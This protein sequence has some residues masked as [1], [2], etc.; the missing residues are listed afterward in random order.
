MYALRAYT[1]P[2]VK[3]A[4]YGAVTQG[5]LSVQ[6]ATQR[7]CETI[8]GQNFACRQPLRSKSSG[9]EKLRRWRC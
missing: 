1:N 7:C 2:S 3:T 4:Y 6:L 5:K 8:G 9:N